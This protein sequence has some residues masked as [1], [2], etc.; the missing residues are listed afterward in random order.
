[1]KTLKQWL[2][3]RAAKAKE[4]DDLLAVAETETRELNTAE[5]D[6]VSRVLTEL[7]AIDAS[8]EIARNLETEALRRS[9]ANQPVHTGVEGNKDTSP[10]E[11]RDLKKF[12]L[13]RGLQLMATGQALDGLELEVHQEAQKDARANGVHIEGFGVPTFINQRGQT[14]TGQ[15]TAAGDQGGVTVPTELNGL[16]EALWAGNFLSE[17][18]ARRLA[19]LQGNQD[20]MVQLTTP[21]IQEK[22]EIEAI[23]DDEITFG[24]ISMA[25]NRRGTSI[26]FSKQLLL[27]SSL[28]VENL[29]IENIRKGLDYKLNAEAIIVLL[30][31]ITAGNGNL[32]AMGANGAVPTYDSV[33]QLE[34]LVDSANANL[35]STKYLTNSK[36]KSQLKRT[37]IF[38]GTNGQPVWSPDNTLNG[39]GAVVSNVIPSNLTKGTAA[40]VCSALVFGNFSDLYLGMWGGADF[41]V[42]NLTKAKTGQV[43]ITVNMF[44]D[45]EVAR[46]K[47]FAGVKDYLTT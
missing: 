38:T 34:G 30:A 7:R 9:I 3:A 29:I 5:Q 22:T 33:V 31:A 4:M 25:P 13:I 37:Q 24:K 44:W 46:A 11:Q 2:E 17:V 47:S 1:M 15:T 8:I 10:G 12:S 14:V 41:I 20:F 43:Q 23:T 27:Q 6:T 39:Y 35:G 26:P 45:I 18:G 40:G 32:L 36:V 28:D 21:T 16:I 42:D 19:G